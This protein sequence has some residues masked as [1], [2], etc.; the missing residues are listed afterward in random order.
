MLSTKG[1][2]NKLLAAK[3]RVSVCE[4]NLAPDIQK[5]WG[6]CMHHSLTFNVC[7]FNVSE[8]AFPAVGTLHDLVCP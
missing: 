7:S 4:K 1:S 8:M 3:L 6:V 2:A 5:I